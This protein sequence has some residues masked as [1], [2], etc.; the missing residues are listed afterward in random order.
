MTL[1]LEEQALLVE[2]SEEPETDDGMIAAGW[3]WSMIDNV[4]DRYRTLLRFDVSGFDPGD[5]VEVATLVM[6]EAGCGTGVGSP[7]GIHRVTEEWDD[8]TVWDQ[9][10]DFG[11]E[12]AQVGYFACTGMVTADVTDLVQHWINEDWD[13]EGLVLISDEETEQTDRY[14]DSELGETSPYVVVNDVP[15]FYG[16]PEIP[17]EVLQTSDTL[18][19]PVAD[20]ALFRDACSGTCTANPGSGGI[21]KVGATGTERF[22]SALRFD[23]SEIP[24]DAFVEQATLH[25]Y[26]TGC[27]VLANNSCPSG[28][29]EIP[30]TALTEGWSRSSAAWP[31]PD[32]LEVSDSSVLV[33][34]GVPTG[35]LT[36]DV[37]PSLSEWWSGSADY[38]LLLDRLPSDLAV[39]G[40]LLAGKDYPVGAY[41]PFI[42]ITYYPDD[43]WFEAWED[44]E[45][46][47]LGRMFSGTSGAWWEEGEASDV[48]T[49]ENGTYMEG[50]IG[51]DIEGVEEGT[52]ADAEPP[53]EPLT[54]VDDEIAGPKVMPY[55]AVVFYKTAIVT[56]EGRGEGPENCTGAMVGADTVLTAGHCVWNRSEKRPDPLEPNGLYWVFPGR[57]SDGT[58]ITN[59]YGKCRISRTPMA[60]RGFRRNPYAWQYDYAAL[61]LACNVGDKTGKFRLS[62]Y[63][64]GFFTNGCYRQSIMTGY[65]LADPP[66]RT[67]EK[68]QYRSKGCVDDVHPMML[69]YTNEQFG[70]SSGSPVYRWANGFDNPWTIMAIHDRRTSAGWTGVRVTAQFIRNVKRWK[71]E[72]KGEHEG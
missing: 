26:V 11:A 29:H 51:E 39:G 25:V 60:P 67:I 24:E 16:P 43:E 57:R 6:H 4:D 49:D 72:P 33:P 45:E 44:E 56:D 48:W 71:R 62:T 54:L 41:R 34:D 7:V 5:P 28:T 18:I 12:L 46:E 53:T 9:Q 3:A 27:L 21:L 2:S 68:T 32:P 35:W 38:G 17:S 30:A 47:E 70:G 22:K 19:L 37:T 8:E 65:P 59:P 40:V 42:E 61:K 64:D 63:S 14:F 31:I 58:T 55:S 15:E 52:E 1:P 69:H 36:W 10:P 20:D 66:E 13:N 23:W 50:T